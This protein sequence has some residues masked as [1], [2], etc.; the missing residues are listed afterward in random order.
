MDG[1]VGPFGNANFLE[2]N[3]QA[4]VLWL[5]AHSAFSDDQPIRGGVPVIFPWFGPGEE[6]D[7]A[8]GFV[9]TATWHLQDTKD[10]LERDGRGR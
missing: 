7:P 4:P 10:T 8:H 9:R 2:V 5:S 6:G 3:G 1:A